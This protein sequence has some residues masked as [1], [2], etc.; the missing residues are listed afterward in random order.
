MSR[1]GEHHHAPPVP[2]PQ[3]FCAHSC[4]TK[5]DQKD[6]VLFERQYVV[7]EP[8]LNLREVTTKVPVMTL[9]VEYKDEKQCVTVMVPKPREIERQVTSLTWLPCTTI[10]PHTGCPCTTYKEVPI[11]RTEKYTVYETVPETKEY[12]VKVPV[13]KPKETSV[14]IQYFT[15]DWSSKAVGYTKFDMAVIPQEIK[16][17]GPC[18]PAL[19]PPPPTCAGPLCP[20]HP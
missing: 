12:T 15:A 13:L 14:S 1:A 18:C 8:E 19:P 5:L 11:C 7:P 10:D 16:L 6:I 9:E 4:G 2:P 20:R 17:P 3:P